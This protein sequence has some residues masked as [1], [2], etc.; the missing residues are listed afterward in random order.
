M[1]YKACYRI[2]TRKLPERRDKSPLGRNHGHFTA[3]HRPAFS[4]GAGAGLFRI[5]DPAPAGRYRADILPQRGAREA[6]EILPFFVTFCHFRFSK[7][8]LHGNQF[9]LPVPFRA[10][11]DPQHWRPGLPAAIPG[12]VSF[13]PLIIL[14]RRQARTGC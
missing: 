12:L 8:R 2:W 10:L 6:P 1:R 4:R 14:S 7:N 13:L 3:R 11:P 9:G 5:A